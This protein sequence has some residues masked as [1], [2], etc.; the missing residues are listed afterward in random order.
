METQT[1]KA[2]LLFHTFC[3]TS[4]ASLLPRAEPELHE[5][6]RAEVTIVTEIRDIKSI[7]A[8]KH[9]SQHHLHIIV[10]LDIVCSAICDVLFTANTHCDILFTACSNT[11]QGKEASH[12]T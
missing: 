7:Y 8:Q 4:T 11:L 6:L 5:H 9:S 12:G 2:E 10:R 1:C 3:K